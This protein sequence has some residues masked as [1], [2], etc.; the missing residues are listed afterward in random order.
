MHSTEQKEISVWDINSARIWDLFDP[1]VIRERPNYN[2]SFQSFRTPIPSKEQYDLII[3]NAHHSTYEK[4]MNK[5][6][7]LGKLGKPVLALTT[8]GGME[9]RIA[10]KKA[11]ATEV[12]DMVT[13]SL[14]IL[15]T[16]D[17]LLLD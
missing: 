14:Q 6:K 10:L 16:I 7:E 3:I 17:R 2:I 1:I 15:A 9:N 13:T 8:N 12:I 11:G 5:L 4:G